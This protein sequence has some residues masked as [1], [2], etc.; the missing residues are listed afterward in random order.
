MAKKGVTQND[1]IRTLTE[2]LNRAA[3]SPNVFAYKPH[4]KQVK[5]HTD[6]ARGRLYIG[7][8]RSGKSVGGVIE[9]IWWLTGR[10]PY[11]KTPPPPIRGRIVGVDFLYGVDKILRPLFAQWM[12]LSDLKGGSWD[13]AYNKEHRTLTLANGSFIEFMSYEQELEKFAGT[14]RHFTHFDEE[15]PQDIFT[16][17]KAR[18]IDTGG[19][20]WMTETPVEGMTWVYDDIYMPGKTGQDVNIGITEIEMKENPYIGQAEIDM[21]MSGLTK[22]EKLARGKGRFVQIGGL[23]FKQFDK[24]IHVVD[25]FVPPLDWEWYVSLDHGFNNPTA[26]LWHA[27]SPEGNIV[28]FSESYE[29]EKTIDQHANTIHARN[30][31]FGRSP[32]TYVGDP[33]MA[34]R[35]AVTGISVFG[36]YAKYEIPFVPG[37]NDVASGIARMSSYLNHDKGKPPKWLITE[38]CS[39][40]IYELQRLRWKTWANKRQ[41]H[42]NNKYDTIHK[43]DDHACDSARY[44][45][46]M[47]PGLEGEGIT[48]HATNVTPFPVEYGEP[49]NQAVNTDWNLSSRFRP[50]N[51]ES[52]DETVG[53]Y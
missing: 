14:S 30:A 25:N 29:R 5:F 4:P 19:S 1:F 46:T 20:W 8:N 53:M 40:F 34:Q 41:A 11:L 31:A 52:F 39:N 51:S 32:D 45:V 21:F 47:L 16:E 13:K 50:D 44:F 15:C 17:C 9:D 48:V 37:I 28:T 24:D 36:E 22:D 26:I 43:K 35:G 7:G 3:L 2:G 33:A 27:V 12:P 42:K 6:P 10:H 38:S 49:T 23:V 18:L